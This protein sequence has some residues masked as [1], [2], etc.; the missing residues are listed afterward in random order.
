MGTKIRTTQRFD[1]VVTRNA[2][3][4]SEGTHHQGEIMSIGLSPETLGITGWSF[5]ESPEEIG[6]F[7]DTE[8]G[9][10]SSEVQ[11]DCEAEKF[12]V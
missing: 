7:P 4:V 2:T 11:C 8:P 1:S 9:D 6:H 5:S 3:A 10:Q 12:C